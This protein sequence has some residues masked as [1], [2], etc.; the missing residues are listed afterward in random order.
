MH[1]IRSEDNSLLGYSAVWSPAISQ[2]AIIFMLAA[3]R[4]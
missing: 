4:T 2:K 3:A 1:I